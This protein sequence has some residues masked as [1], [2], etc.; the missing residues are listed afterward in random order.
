MGPKLVDQIE[1][2]PNDDLLKHIVHEQSSLSLNPVDRNHALNA[3]KQLKNGKATGPD[4]IPI[5]L[6]KDVTDLLSQPLTMIFT[7]SLRK[8]IFPVTWKVAKVTPIFKS[9][10][11][12]EANN[13]RAISVVS[14]VS[15]FSRILE[16]IVRNQTYEYLKA[17]KALTMSQSAFQK[18]CSTITSLIDSTGNW[19]E[20]IHETSNSF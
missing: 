3:T 2:N 5:M 19:H 18:Y 10:F 12:S 1:Q 6:I 17:T 9:G 20:N 7:S 16:R 15:V 4:K 11:R 13:Y 8:G 14:V